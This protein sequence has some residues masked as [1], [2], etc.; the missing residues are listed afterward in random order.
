MTLGKLTELTIFPFSKYSRISLTA[1]RAQL[2]SDSGVEAPKWG[3][4]IIFSISTRS[5]VAKSVTYLAIFPSFTP[6][7]IS[8]DT[9]RSALAKFKILT[10]SFIKA[11]VSLL[12]IPFVSFVLGACN[13]I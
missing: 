2:S 13:V 10:P 7:K 4:T 8:C 11:I 3:I 5:G 12:M 1:I 6:S 9:T